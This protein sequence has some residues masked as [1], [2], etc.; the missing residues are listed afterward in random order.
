MRSGR[1]GSAEPSRKWKL[2]MPVAFG[3]LAMLLFGMPSF[4]PTFRPLLIVLRVD[5]ET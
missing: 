5:V 4:V 3:S 1:P 2:G